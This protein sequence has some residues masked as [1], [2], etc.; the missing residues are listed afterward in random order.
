MAKKNGNG[1]LDWLIFE[2]QAQICKAFANPMRLKIIDMLT[3]GECRF[4]EIQGEIDVSK[5]NLSQHL[6]ILKTAGIV[7]VRRDGKE[8]ICSLAMPEVKNACNIIRDVLRVQ[9]RHT[10]RLSV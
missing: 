5:A 1:D 3:R 7:H 8:V 10:R 2:R 9:I 6:T 4:S